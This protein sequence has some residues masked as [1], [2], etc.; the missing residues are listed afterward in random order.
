[1]E[2]SEGA[3]NSSLAMQMKTDEQVRLWKTGSAYPCLR[4]NQC[5]QDASEA[6]HSA[7]S[8]KGTPLWIY[9]TPMM[10]SS[11]HNTS[12]ITHT[13]LHAPCVR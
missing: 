3:S 5:F 9:I 7:E 10:H 6:V 8:R 12:V 2:V 1:M 4:S 11:T 13:T